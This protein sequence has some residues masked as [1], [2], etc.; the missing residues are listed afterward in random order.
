MEAAGA[1]AGT[2]TVRNIRF[3]L[4][5][6]REMPRGLAKRLTAEKNDPKV[7][8]IVGGEGDL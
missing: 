1:A 3:S 7:I 2:T 4:R 8:I 6:P 5:K